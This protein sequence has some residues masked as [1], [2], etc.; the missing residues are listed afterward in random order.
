[1]SVS[2]I[3]T[4]I[5]LKKWIKDG[6][7]IGENVKIER[8][9]SIDPSFPWLVKIGDDVTIA[10]D[11]LILCHDGSTKPF[12]GN[13]RVG[14]V[15]IGN[16]VFIGAKS[17]ILPNVKIGDNV[18]I[19][20]SSV[21]TKDVPDGVVVSGVPAKKIC[22]IDEFILKHKSAMKKHTVFNKEYTHRGK[23]TYDKKMEMLEV[24]SN[25]FGYI[26]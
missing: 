23:I 4:Q 11:C 21:V 14:V 18:I 6:L 10:P 3:I 16:H 9:V 7:I 13:S 26:D 19:G 20:S 1:M 8:G 24:L 25:D 22:D 17:V 15:N 12:V 2:R 5:K